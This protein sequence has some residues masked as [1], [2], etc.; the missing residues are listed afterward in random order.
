MPKV[1]SEAE[2]KEHRAQIFDKGLKLIMEKGYKNVTVDQLV[3]L[4][5]ASKGYFYLLFESKESFFLDAIAWQMENIFNAMKEARDR[6]ASS[7]EIGNLYRQLLKKMHFASYEDIVYVQK[8]V[9]QKEWEKFREFEKIYFTKIL[10]L[11]GRDN[12]GCDPEVISN[13]SALIYLS[14]NMKQYAQY[15][16]PEKSDEVTEILLDTLH[17]YIYG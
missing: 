2:K 9:S 4:I 8:K 14:H 12:S 3:Q 7:E 13:L 11:I 5:H 17:R 16:F 1:F 15:L 10:K 6:G